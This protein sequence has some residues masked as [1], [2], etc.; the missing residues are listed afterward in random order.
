MQKKNIR[1]SNLFAFCFSFL[2][3]LYGHTS[4]TEVDVTDN[5]CMDSSYKQTTIGNSVVRSFW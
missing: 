3:P 2:R 5:G 4:S 1:S